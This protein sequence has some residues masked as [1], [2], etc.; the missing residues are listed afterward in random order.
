MST[1]LS[2]ALLDLTDPSGETVPAHSPINIRRHRSADRSAAVVVGR[3][4]VGPVAPGMAPVFAGG[5]GLLGEI[6]DVRVL[7]GG[8]S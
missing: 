1:A 6:G 3:A 4:A 2:G 5:M 7:V 8:V